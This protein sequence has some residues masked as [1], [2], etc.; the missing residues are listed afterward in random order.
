MIM[1]SRIIVPMTTRG[2]RVAS[3]FK[4]NGDRAVVNV[5][6]CYI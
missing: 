2:V 3:L 6:L 4:R 5:V 1:L